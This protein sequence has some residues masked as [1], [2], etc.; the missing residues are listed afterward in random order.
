M[1]LGGYAQTST[2]FANFTLFLKGHSFTNKEKIPECMLIGNFIH[3]SL[4]KACFLGWNLELA[5][6]FGAD[7]SGAD[8]RN[9]NLKGANLEY[10]DLTNVMLKRTYLA[11]ANLTRANLRCAKYCNDP[12]AKTI[13]PEGFDPKEHGMIEVD[14]D[15][16]T[17]K[18]K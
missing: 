2:A 14:I 12:R 8:F 9:A 17:V 15:G 10:A 18:D 13:F 16:K 5:D 1:L 4:N 6:L 7:L 11:G 3:G